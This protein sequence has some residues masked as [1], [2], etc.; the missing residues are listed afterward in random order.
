MRRLISSNQKHSFISAVGLGYL[1]YR[2]NAEIGTNKIEFTGATLG[3][4]IGLNY[5]FFISKSV[6][7]GAGAKYVSGNISKINIT[8]NGQTQ[9]KSI[10]DLSSQSRESLTN[11]NL[12][13][14]LRFYL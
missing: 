11:I 14:G 2:N 10:K 7:V 5:D 9:T 3:L 4:T 13:A 1:G 12:T 8:S 6:A